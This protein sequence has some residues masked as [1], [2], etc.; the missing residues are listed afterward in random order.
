[1]TQFYKNMFGEDVPVFQA[2]EFEPLNSGKYKRLKQY[3]RAWKVIVVPHDKF[4]G[5]RENEAIVLSDSKLGNS[6]LHVRFDVTSAMSTPVYGD[7]TVYNLSQSL[8]N[9]LADEGSRVVVVAGYE[10]G[11]EGVVWNGNVFHFIQYQQNVV[12]RVLLM[13]CIFGRDIITDNFVIA[14]ITGGKTRGERFEHYTQNI[15]ISIKRSEKMNQESTKTV[16]REIIFGDPMTNV[17]D[18]AHLEGRVVAFDKGGVLTDANIATEKSELPVITVSPD[19]GLIGLPTQIPRGVSFQT[20]LDPRLVFDIPA[21]EVELVNTEVMAQQLSLGQPPPII[22]PTG[23]YRIASVRH[24]GDTRGNEWYSYVEGIID[25]DLY[26][27][28][29]G[30]GAGRNITMNGRH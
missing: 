22:S 28:A 26:A 14:S 30:T 21:R 8:I 15:N 7:I 23:K 11:N 20:L 13:H 27:T 4:T 1:M 16:R 9:Q 6:A 17:H 24:V 2:T 18:D 29:V 5:Y 10:D 12:D 19:T 3:R 25:P